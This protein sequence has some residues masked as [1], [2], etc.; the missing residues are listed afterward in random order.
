MSNTIPSMA[1]DG[2]WD[3]GYEQ[4]GGNRDLLDKAEP[5][6]RFGSGAQAKAVALTDPGPR[7]PLKGTIRVL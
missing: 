5:L 1:Q 4:Y 7:V 3:T 6:Q 2:A